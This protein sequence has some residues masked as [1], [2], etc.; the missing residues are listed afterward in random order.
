M[1]NL[2]IKANVYIY[3]AA[4]PAIPGE[5]LHLRFD[6]PLIVSENEKNVAFYEQAN[7]K[8]PLWIIAVPNSNNYPEV[9]DGFFVYFGEIIT[10]EKTRCFKK[11]MNYRG[12]DP[13]QKEIIEMSIMGLIYAAC[14]PVEKGVNEGR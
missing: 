9:R 12:A 4:P 1:K 11:S 14:C 8:A 2:S 10:L 5:G 6:S 7:L 13:I 3:R